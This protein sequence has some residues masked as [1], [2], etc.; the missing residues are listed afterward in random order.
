MWSRRASELQAATAANQFL[1]HANRWF[2]T[3]K[4]KEKTDRRAQKPAEHPAEVQRESQLTQWSREIITNTSGKKVLLFFPFCT[5]C[6][7]MDHW[8]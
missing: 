8:L 2:V 4:H 3:C 7:H 6:V 1:V 5:S